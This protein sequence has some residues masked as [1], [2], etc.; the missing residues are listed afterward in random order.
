MSTPPKS[1]RKTT[2]AR[3]RAPRG[4]GRDIV[5][6]FAAAVTAAREA[7][8]LSRADLAQAAGLA[9]STMYAIESEQRSPSLRVAA[10]LARALGMKAWLDDPAVVVRVGK[11]S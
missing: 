9:V 11:N 7:A 8:G 1:R 4:E 10:A 3:P 6:G 5:P 2:A